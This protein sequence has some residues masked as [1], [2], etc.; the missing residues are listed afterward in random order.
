M[1]R[2]GADGEI[3]R[4]RQSQNAVAVLSQK[5]QH[6]APDGGI[7]RRGKPVKLLFIVQIVGGGCFHMTIIYPFFHFVKS[8]E[9]R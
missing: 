6:L 5:A 8:F 1:K 4:L 9:F 3:E 2:C 7:E